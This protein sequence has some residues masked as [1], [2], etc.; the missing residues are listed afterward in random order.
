MTIYRYEQHITGGNRM[1]RPIRGGWVWDEERARKLAELLRE[2]LSA[3]KM[4]EELNRA[5]NAQLTKGN[6]EAAFRYKKVPGL[7]RAVTEDADELIC[8]YRTREGKTGR[9]EG[10]KDLSPRG[11]PDRD[12][13]KTARPKRY[14]KLDSD[15]ARDRLLALRAQK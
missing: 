8:A 5:F 4:A 12:Y 11:T 15:T 14:K 9:P 10:A 13:R 3:S 1:P 6:I 2:R 7:L